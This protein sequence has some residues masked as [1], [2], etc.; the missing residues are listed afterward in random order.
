MPL[1]FTTL[2]GSLSS[3]SCTSKFIVGCPLSLLFNTGF[4]CEEHNNPADF[5]L[6]VVMLCE[7]K[8]NFGK[9]IANK[10]HTR[11]TIKSQIHAH[12]VL[13]IACT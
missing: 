5:F 1:S 4:E 9:L 13:Y 10:I 6:D 8:N 7:D 11:C 3:N 2:P 12:V